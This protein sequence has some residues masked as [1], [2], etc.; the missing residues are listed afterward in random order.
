MV[1]SCLLK[2]IVTHGQSR[3]ETIYNVL[4]FERREVELIGRDS[5][6]KNKKKNG[7]RKSREEPRTRTNVLAS[8]ASAFARLRFGDDVLLF[9]YMTNIIV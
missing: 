6:R 7:E 3:Q 5:Q 9:V 1:L 4:P 2:V 8:L